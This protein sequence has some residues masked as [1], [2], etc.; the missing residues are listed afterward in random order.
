MD[1]E[2][3]DTVNADVKNDIDR[4]SSTD[5]ANMIPKAR[6]DQVNEKK[7]AAEAEL[8]TIADDIRNDVPEDMRNLIP[9]LPAGHLIKWLRAANTQG[10]FVQ[11]TADALD[12]KRANEKKTI[13]YDD[14][15][16]Q[17]KIA[18]GYKT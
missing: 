8:Q 4:T 2:T 5:T 16:P 11:K 13:N 15:S 17:Q 1:Q 14:M 18:A 3:K 10:L 6:F 7:K 9:D 12:T